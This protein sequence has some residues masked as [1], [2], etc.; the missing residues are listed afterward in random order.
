MEKGL[1]LNEQVEPEA[2]G[3]KRCGAGSSVAQGAGGQT[4]FGT[5]DPAEM[6]FF[7][8]PFTGSRSFSNVLSLEGKAKLE[9]K[10]PS[11][12]G[13]G[14]KGAR[15]KSSTQRSNS[16]VGSLLA[17]NRGNFSDGNRT[18]AQASRHLHRF[19]AQALELV[20][21]IHLVHF[22]LA[23]ENVLGAA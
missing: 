8:S 7:Q 6:R 3:S 17:S 23:D 5:Q 4:G 16:A 20:L 11:S 12:Q 9:T 10:R 14:Q 1:M 2:D 15:L 18:V 21:S 19:P 22:P 13:D